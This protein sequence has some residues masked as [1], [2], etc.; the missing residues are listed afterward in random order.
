[1]IRD[2]GQS[3]KGKGQCCFF[4]QTAYVFTKNISLQPLIL[5]NMS[6]LETIRKR[7]KLLVIIIGASLVTFVLEDAL[8]SGRFFFGGNDNTIAIVNGKKIDYTK[9]RVDADNAIEKEKASLGVESLR[10]SDV[11]AAV[12]TTFKNMIFG[13]VL[14]PEYKK[15]GINVP[16]SELTDLM[17][18]S[19]PAPDIYR[20]FSD[21]K[22][23]ISKQFMDPRT[24][25]LNM[26][27]VIRY[28]KQMNEQDQARWEMIEDKVKNDEMQAKYFYLLMNAVFIPDAVAKM[29]NEDATKT[30][31]ISYVLK[32]YADI[33][34]NGITVSDQDITDYYNK[35]LYEYNQTDESRR[36]DYV[37]FNINPTDTDMMNIHR[38]VD[39]MY[40]QFKQLKPNEDSGFI[41]ATDAQTFD[42]QYHKAGE[43]PVLIDSVMTHCEVG[44]MYGPYMDDNKYKIAKLLDISDLPDSSRYSQIFIPAPNGDFDKIKPFADSIKA[45]SK[46]DN[47]ADLAKANSKDPESAEKGGDEG[48]V[49]RGKELTSNPD[50]EHQIFFGGVGNVIELKLQQGYLILCVTAQTPRIKSYKVGIA[51]KNIEPSQATQQKVYAQA[52]DFEGKNHTSDAFEKA[53]GQMNRRVVDIGENET[54]LAGIQSAKEIIRWAYDH[55]EGDVSDVENTGDNKYVIAHIM[56]V[57]KMGTI[58]L[59]Q[60]KDEIKLKVAVDKKAEKIMA[61]MKSALAGGLSSVAQKVGSSIDTA[62]GLTFNSDDIPSVGKEDAVLGTMSA[63]NEGAVSQPIQGE[64]GVFVIKVESTYYTNK[65]DYRFTQIQEMK[66]MRNQAPNEAYNA[67]VKKAGVISH[68]GRYY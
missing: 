62:S 17:L 38:D 33:P 44:T 63:L 7:A 64:L 11:T 25:G 61:D 9:F 34:D 3:A 54:S 59:A 57:T 58:P 56:Q 42:Y 51:M 41:V 13:M 5:K 53:A 50:L 16:D 68:L 66:A 52:S 21:G 32:R 37:T 19:H 40:S 47:F 46:V 36:V 23:H 4:H 22:G 2:V 10:D 29:D 28:V 18:G 30:Y 20:L 31:K 27:N 55:K 45:I 60:V 49:T 48:W 1:L 65:T 26:A 24:G 35:H 15:L 6:V 67:L 43:L 12:Q 39:S 14:G 8:T